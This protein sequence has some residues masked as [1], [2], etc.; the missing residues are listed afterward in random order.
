M[1]KNSSHSRLASDPRSLGVYGVKEAA[2]Y[3]GLPAATLRA[4]VMGR[5]Y[6]TRQGTRTALP[7]IRIPEPTPPRLSFYNLCEA[8]V[9]G[10]IRRQHHVALPDVRRAVDYLRKHFNTVHPL[11]EKAMETDGKDLFIS[12]MGDLVAITRGGQITIREALETYLRRIERDPEGLPVKLFP[13][14][15]QAIQDAPRNVVID[16]RVAFGRPVITGTNVPTSVIAERYKAG[17]SIRDLMEDYG[18]EAAEI[19][20]A[21]RCE[22]DLKAA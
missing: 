17:D 1:P 15:R 3:L 16:A 7:V 10:A 13:F 9:L 20:E 12:H 8:H 18:R 21:I 2:H 19:E 4:W 14:T 11:I 5:P 22:L 6:A